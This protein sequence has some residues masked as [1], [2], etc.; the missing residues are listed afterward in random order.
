MCVRFEHSTTQRLLDESV[1]DIFKRS[2]ILSC[3]CAAEELDKFG[4]GHFCRCLFSGRVALVLDAT[5]GRI[6]FLFL[7]AR[8][9]RRVQVCSLVIV[10][11][12]SSWVMLRFSRF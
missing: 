4:F 7:S 1:P 3:D 12:E 9:N 11:K 10:I 5:F 2:R 6:L 8:P